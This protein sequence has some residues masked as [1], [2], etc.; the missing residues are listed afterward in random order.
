M[1]R[2]KNVVVGDDSSFFDYLATSR[3]S[4]NGFV[5]KDL[6]SDKDI[7]SSI[8]NS[9]NELKNSLNGKDIVDKVYIIYIIEKE[10]YT[11]EVF[12][13]LRHLSMQNNEI[14]LSAGSVEYSDINNS[15]ALNILG[16]YR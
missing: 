3:N 9:F 10:Q 6:R 1:S 14:K 13:L 8:I 2:F 7:K 4:T 11:E 16:R 15:T 12:W 5:I